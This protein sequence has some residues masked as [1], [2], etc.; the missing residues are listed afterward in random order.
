MT[1]EM[2]VSITLERVATICERIEKQLDTHERL[3]EDHEIRIRVVE[4]M[5][6]KMVG[7][8]LFTTVIIIPV[9]VYVIDRMVG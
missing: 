6:S 4:D 7:I 3:F 8:Y 9:V 5:K 1:E 2:R